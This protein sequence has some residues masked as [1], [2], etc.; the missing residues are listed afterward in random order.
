MKYNSYFFQHPCTVLHFGL[1]L[2]LMGLRQ[3]QPILILQICLLTT[4]QR[5]VVRERNGQILMKHLSCPLHLRTLQHI[6]N[7]CCTV[8]HFPICWF[9]FLISL[10]SGVLSSFNLIWRI[11][12][13]YTQNILNVVDF[14]LKQSSDWMSACLKNVSQLGWELLWVI[15]FWTSAIYLIRL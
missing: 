8:F 15:D 10:F 5:T 4:N 12:T 13:N 14:Y 6:G 11:K 3:H 7:R 9:V 2:N 1:M